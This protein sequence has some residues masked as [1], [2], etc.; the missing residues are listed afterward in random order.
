MK[1]MFERHVLPWIERHTPPAIHRINVLCCGGGES[2]IVD[3]L[4]DII[5]QIQ[6]K[7][8]LSF[9]TRASD[10]II[11]LKLTGPDLAELETFAQLIEA[12]LGQMVFGRNNATLAETVASLLTQSEE[13]LAVAESCTA[14]GVGEEITTVAGSSRFFL[15]GWITYSNE[16]KNRFLKVPSEILDTDGAVSEACVQAMTRGALEQSGADWAIAVSGIAGPGGGTAEKPVG[17][18]Y[19]GIGRK[20]DIRVYKRT[21]S[22]LGREAIRHRATL[23]ALNYLRLRLLEKGTQPEG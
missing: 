3:Q 7:P 20:D 13:T 11:A 4:S 12:R 23:T 18:V 17:L 14:G 19:F 22:N 2:D 6:A 9:G 8:E 21:F 16:F 1:G 5:Q 10:S 15:G